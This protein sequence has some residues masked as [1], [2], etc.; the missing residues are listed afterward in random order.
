MCI[1]LQYIDENDDDV[2]QFIATVWG[3]SGI[4]LLVIAAVIAAATGEYFFKN[5]ASF[6]SLT[7]SLTCTADD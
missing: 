2:G 3:I 4:G 7:T 1:F 6:C 5:L